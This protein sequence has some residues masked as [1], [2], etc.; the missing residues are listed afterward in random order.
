MAYSAEADLLIGDM[1]LSGTVDKTKFIDGAAEE[2]D[3]KL[4][5]IYKLPLNPLDEAVELPLA[6]RLLLK[7][8]NNKL[9]SGEL[10][11]AVAIG[12]EDTAL[13][14]YGNRLVQE[15]K[16]ELLL[17]ANG[18]VDLSA[19]RLTGETDTATLDRVPGIKNHDEESAVDAFENA[20]MRS[21]PF[22]WRPGEVT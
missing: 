7:T 9:A 2:I 10:I 5:F 19:E 6:Q 14:A 4:G 22:Y 1:M 20:F 17:L 13:H 11:M 15:A 3:A 16:A 18:V 12:G 8:I 21:K